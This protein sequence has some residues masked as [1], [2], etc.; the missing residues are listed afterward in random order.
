MKRISVRKAAWVAL[1]WGGFIL[2]IR[3]AGAEEEAQGFREDVYLS[4]VDQDARLPQSVRVGGVVFVSATTA[5]GRDLEQQMRMCYLRIQS[6]LGAHGLTMDAVT[7]ER[8]YALDLE[9]LEKAKGM[10]ELYYSGKHAP[11]TSWVE[12]SGLAQ[13]GA[14]LA[15]EVMAVGNPEEE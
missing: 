9:A 2:A 14:L 12:V 7:M 3:S 11:A 10:R 5:P 13:E 15:I 8:I 1:V 6:S 4:E